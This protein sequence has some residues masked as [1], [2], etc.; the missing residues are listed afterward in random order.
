MFISF[1]TKKAPIDGKNIGIHE[2]SHSDTVL[3]V[4]IEFGL[5]QRSRPLSIFKIYYFK[6]VVKCYIHTSMHTFCM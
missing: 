6:N 3:N 5:M 1:F 2:Q 4:F